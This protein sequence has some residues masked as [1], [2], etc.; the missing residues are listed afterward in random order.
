MCVCIHTYMCTHIHVHIH[1][2]IHI[3]QV[4]VKI[5]QATYLIATKPEHVFEVTDDLSKRALEAS[6]PMLTSFHHVN[7]HTSSLLMI[8][9]YS[10]MS[11]ICFALYTRFAFIVQC[12]TFVFLVLLVWVLYVVCTC[13]NIPVCVCICVC[14]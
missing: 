5:F 12:N 8:R 4:H 10:A 2:Y 11:Y 1:I 13:I 6:T 3:V 14:E 9:V 7:I